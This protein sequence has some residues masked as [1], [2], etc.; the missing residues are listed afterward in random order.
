[1]VANEA[2]PTANGTNGTNGTYQPS[3]E[4]LKLFALQQKYNEEAAKRTRTDGLSQ[5]VELRQAGS[6]RLRSL[7]EDPWADHAALDAKEQV[8]DGAVYKFVVTGAGYGG[9]LFA[10]RLIDAGL[11]KGREDLLM[12]DTAGGFGGT[13]WWNRY[14]GLH[15]DVESYS[16]MPLLEETG[17]VPKKKYASGPELLEHAERI[18]KHY[19]LH[20]K[21]L[22]RSSVTKA[23]WDETSQLW[24]VDITEGR[25][26]R[27]QD[28][29][30][31]QV[32]AQYVLLAS[33]VLVHPQVPKISGLEDFTGNMFHT[34][35]WDYEVTG[36]SPTDWN[37]SKLEGKRVGIIGTGATAI[38]V[39][40]QLA[41]FAKEVYVFQRTPSSVDARNQRDTDPEE[42]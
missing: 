20:D 25:G 34:A 7:E 1:M 17:Y 42:W 37:L 13:W 16:Y 36:G 19:H 3:E 41:K 39:V 12:V 10:A 32:K 5:F 15:C 31:L 2:G 29:R 24:T 22:F 14:P 28:K 40:P 9:E 30:Q 33:G 4:D 8:Q 23:V 38:Q 35:R 21:V 18:A 6:V 26:P 11:V 27:G